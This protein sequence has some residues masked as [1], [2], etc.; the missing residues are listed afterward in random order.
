MDM[1]FSQLAPFWGLIL[2]S[3]LLVAMAF[4][5][6]R[7]MQ[8]PKW[9]SG[10]MIAIFVI[11][12]MTVV[13]WAESG[14]RMALAA[15]V[16]AVGFAGFALRLLGGGDVKALSVML[17]LVPVSSM[18]LFMLVFSASLMLGVLAVLLARRAFGGADAAWVSMQSTAFPMGISIAAAGLV[19]PFAA[20][21]I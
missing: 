17:L 1:M 3:P 12:G 16:F 18:A 21:M 13:P 9:I 5:D 7:D 6:L 10:G 15:I 2:A 8:I 14:A 4:H 20:T 11:M 19:L